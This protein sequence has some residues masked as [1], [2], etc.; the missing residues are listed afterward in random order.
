MNQQFNV[1]SVVG[2]AVVIVAA[3]DADGPLVHR[4]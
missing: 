2:I 3:G 1:K 4:G